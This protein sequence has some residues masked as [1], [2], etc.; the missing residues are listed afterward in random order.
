MKH[1]S[2]LVLLSLSLVLLICNTASAV[3]LNETWDLSPTAL[4]KTQGTK[5]FPYTVN[6]HENGSYN[7]NYV[8]LNYHL[9]EVGFYPK[10]YANPV[11]WYN[12]GIKADYKNGGY[13]VGSI[14]YNDWT[15]RALYVPPGKAVNGGENWN[16]YSLDRRYSNCTADYTTIVSASDL[17][18]PLTRVSTLNVY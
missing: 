15:Q 6:A 4:T 3:S 11:L 10:H 2:I 12:V 1:K 9:D 16:S 5:A 7:G 18:A 13:I 17:Y 8:V 14:G